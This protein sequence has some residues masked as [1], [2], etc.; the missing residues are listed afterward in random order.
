[1]QFAI[2]PTY[3]C[4]LRC[5]YCFERDLSAW[6]MRSMSLVEVRN[7]FAA[8]EAIRQERYPA[9]DAHLIL[10]GGEPL[11]RSVKPCV[12]HILQEA[13]VRGFGVEVVTNG[14]QIRHFLDLLLPRREIIRQIQITLDGPPE[15]HDRRR[16]FRS[17][18]GTFSRIVR[19]VDLLLQKG[20]PITIRINVDRE[21]ITSLPRL[22]AYMENR[23]WTL[24]P[25]FS[26][27]MYPVTAY[28]DPNRPSI[29]AED[30]VLSELQKMF[31]GEGGQMPAFALYG[32]KVLGHVA[33]VLDP[34]SLPLRMPP[35][36]TYCEANGLRYFA[37]GPDGLIYPCGQGVGR[38]PL[39]VGR[40][41]P[42]FELWQDR[43]AQWAQRSVMTIPQCR[44]CPLA[45]LCGG[46]CAFGAWVRTGSLMEP[47]CQ[48]SPRVLD[49]YIERM[50]PR[51]TQ[52]APGR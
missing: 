41:H 39:A 15:V 4:N 17:G 18:A 47:N 32:F 24:Y 44:S 27:Y 37:F 52:A 36:F 30:E 12:D 21:N 9:A 5:T 25:N 31:R 34:S 48:G 50:I 49:R 46:G 11:M 22:I 14:V 13:E 28:T 3:A 19:N 1:M 35:L 2:C 8:I 43:C 6:P 45:T 20:M 10:F 29:L 38:Q 7:A 26:C 33:S 40:F 42:F 23:G 51:I 16:M